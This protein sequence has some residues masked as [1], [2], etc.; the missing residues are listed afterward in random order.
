MGNPLSITVYSKPSC[1]QCDATKK[2]LKA[3]GLPFRELDLT[4]PEQEAMLARAKELG[5]LS[6]PFVIVNRPGSDDLWS[7]Y[8]PDLLEALA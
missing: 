7:G 5:H 4:L 8:R 6:A 1:V 3:L 2:K